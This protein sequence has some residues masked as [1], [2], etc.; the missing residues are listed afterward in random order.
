MLPK[1]CEALSAGIG[2][3]CDRQCGCRAV[4]GQWVLG[5]VNVI[6]FLLKHL[7]FVDDLADHFALP[8]VDQAFFG[9]VLV[10]VLD[11]CQVGLV[12]THVRNA[13][14]SRRPQGFAVHLVVAV[15]VGD[16]VDVLDLLGIIRR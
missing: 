7:D 10:P 12:D 2:S 8:E 13:G 9:D 16:G 3:R 5:K 4:I 14:H 11:E 1:T 15:R 6:V